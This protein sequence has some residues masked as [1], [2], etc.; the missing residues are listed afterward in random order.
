MLDP[1]NYT[2]ILLN[3]NNWSHIQLIQLNSKHWKPLV[4]ARDYL[5]LVDISN[6]NVGMQYPEPPKNPCNCPPPSMMPP[7]V[8]VLDI[9]GFDNDA[10]A[11]SSFKAAQV[12]EEYKAIFLG[13]NERAK[14]A[15]SNCY[16]HLKITWHLL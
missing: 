5:M 13:L 2:F 8:N 1:T 6:I 16:C 7:R 3:F 15:T 14:K 9:T 10:T 12:V 4:I 11:K